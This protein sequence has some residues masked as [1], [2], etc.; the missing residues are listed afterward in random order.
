MKI[1]I[2][3]APNTDLSFYTNRGLNLEVEYKNIPLTPFPLTQV[4]TPLGTI[5]STPNV[6]SYLET[7]YKTFQYSIIIIGWNPNDYGSQVA[8]TGGY[9][10]TTPLSCGTYFCSVRQDTQPVNMYPVHE[11]MHA[12]GLIINIG[13]NDHTPKDFMDTTPVLQNGQISWLPFYINDP[14]STDPQSNFNQTWK[15]YIPFLPRL[16]AITYA[17]T[18]PQT[19]LQAT[20]TRKSDDGVQ[21]LGEL[22]IGGFTAKTLERPWKNNQRD[23]SCIPKGTYLCKY[24]FSMGHLGWTYAVQN[25]QGRTGI[26]IH[27]GNY[28]GD[29]EGC[30]LL[31]N[32]YEDINNDGEVDIINSKITI[33]A[34]ETL[35]QKKDFT[36]IIQ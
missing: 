16:N 12:L 17:S 22:V 3:N 13:F 25:V 27:S 31:G 36:L 11:M 9:T 35:M 4:P 34:F 10:S 15:N 14:N 24:L 32:A 8:S 26:R 6:K 19:S 5:I 2:I 29:V 28:V 1:L 7:V 21:T 20:L 18:S 30:I 23:I 33:K